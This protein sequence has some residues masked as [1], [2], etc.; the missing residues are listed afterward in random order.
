VRTITLEFLATMPYI[1]MEV[2]NQ[3]IDNTSLNELTLSDLLAVH[4]LPLVSYFEIEMNYWYTTLLI[5]YLKF[6]E[7]RF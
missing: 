2:V 3:Y 5:K 1:K 7:W 6:M 4:L